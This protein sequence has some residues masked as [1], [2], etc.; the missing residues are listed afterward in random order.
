MADMARFWCWT[1]TANASPS[2]EI[3]HQTT[4]K[5]KASRLSRNSNWQ[6]SN[7]NSDERFW[8]AVAM[9]MIEK[10]HAKKRRQ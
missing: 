1:T 4:E 7:L 8:T 6:Q 5:T 9:Q 2:R 10:P 3:H